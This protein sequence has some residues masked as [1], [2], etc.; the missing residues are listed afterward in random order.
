MSGSTKDEDIL[1]IGTENV[2]T[3]TTGPETD[4]IERLAMK[5]RERIQQGLRDNTLTTGSISL[6]GETPDQSIE[7]STDRKLY[8]LVKDYTPNNRDTA[9]KLLAENPSN[10]TRMVNFQDEDGDTVLHLAVSKGDNWLAYKLVEKGAKTKVPNKSGDMV[11]T[12]TQEANTAAAPASDA[13]LTE[14]ENIAMSLMSEG[15]KDVENITSIFKK[16]I[17][18]ANKNSEIDTIRLTET[19][20]PKIY[21]ETSAEPHAR[22]TEDMVSTEDFVKNTRKI[23]DKLAS[24]NGGG[25]APKSISGIRVMNRLQPINDSS[26]DYAAHSSELARMENSE[27]TDAHERMVKKV[28]ELMSVDERTARALKF[29]VQKMVQ[30]KK[31]ELS[32][33]DLAAEMEKSLNKTN[34]NKLNKKIDEVKSNYEK[35]R[36]EKKKARRERRRSMSKESQKG[37][38]YS[39]DSSDYS[40]DSDYE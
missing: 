23:L 36:E 20:A 29:G 2:G 5:F 7:V 16:Y 37:G 30:D 10:M 8:D 9:L 22:E 19:H 28:M 15:N 25:R 12:E 14:T 4:V 3:E 26:E 11:D 40:L 38:A 21:S 1:S 34:L 6:T 31:P 27:L 18:R 33:E 24:Q 35:H 17:D 13:L 32:Q 39:D